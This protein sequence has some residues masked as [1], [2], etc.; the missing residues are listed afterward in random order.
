VDYFAVMSSRSSSTSHTHSDTSSPNTTTLAKYTQQLVSLARQTLNSERTHHR[1]FSHVLLC[2]EYFR[3][4]E[5]INNCFA[6]RLSYEADSAERRVEIGILM[7]MIETGLG[8]GRVERR[9]K[10]RAGGEKEEGVR[11]RAYEEVDGMVFG[12]LCVEGC[13]GKV[14]R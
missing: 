8:V 1:R 6:G 12:R 5:R 4:R 14:E 2:D 10:W 7:G 13:R 3:L 9:S 11:R